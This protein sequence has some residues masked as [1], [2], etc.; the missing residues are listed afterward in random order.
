MNLERFKLKSIRHSINTRLDERTIKKFNQQNELG[1]HIE[2]L[3]SLREPAAELV[4]HK[5]QCTDC[6][7]QFGMSGATSRGNFF[8][9][10]SFP[11]S[12]RDGE[13]LDSFVKNL[14][15]VNGVSREVKSVEPSKTNWSKFTIGVIYSASED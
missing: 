9:F 1:L 15:S 3:A 5:S 2:T 8:S 4:G 6:E 11:L 14:R 13:E 7:P 10:T 12:K